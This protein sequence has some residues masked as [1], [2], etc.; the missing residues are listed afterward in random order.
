MNSTEMLRQRSCEQTF[1]KIHFSVV[2]GQ[3]RGH[4]STLFVS[5][6]LT[7]IQLLSSINYCSTFLGSHKISS[8]CCLYPHLFS[9]SKAYLRKEIFQNLGSEDVIVLNS[10]KCMSFY[11]GDLGRIICIIETVACTFTYNRFI[12]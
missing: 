6:S 7:R 5:L 12:L 2:L 1:V 8:N 11:S 9:L 4:K 10:R 3:Y